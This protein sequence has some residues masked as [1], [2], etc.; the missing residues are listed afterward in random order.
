MVQK[1]N[2][3]QRQYLKGLAHALEPVVIIGEKGLT[4][5]VVKEINVNLTAHELIKVRVL[6]DDREAR[7]RL[8]NEMCEQ[9]SALL[10]QHIGKLLVL[11][12]PSEKKKISL[13]NC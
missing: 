9:V 5:S 6:G 1:I 2:V 4:P 12:R 13:P 8:L 7:M 11:Y 3:K 10:V